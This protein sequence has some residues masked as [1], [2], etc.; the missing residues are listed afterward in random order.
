MDTAC[1]IHEEARDKEAASEDALLEGKQKSTEHV[2]NKQWLSSRIRVQSDIDQEDARKAEDMAHQTDMLQ[3]QSSHN[4][5]LRQVKYKFS[6]LRNQIEKERMMW[7]V[8]AKELTLKLG[9]NSFIISKEQRKSR[10]TVK[11]QVDKSSMIIGEDKRKGIMIP[12]KQMDK[13]LKQE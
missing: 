1:S 6:S 4:S 2:R 5:S 7:Q 13:S 12:Q 8:L 9:N 3:L 10:V 11:K